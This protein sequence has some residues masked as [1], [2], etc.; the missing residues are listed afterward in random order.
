METNKDAPLGQS[1]L[2]SGLHEGPAGH[3]LPRA[4]PDRVQAVLRNRE[5]PFAI[6]LETIAVELIAIDLQ[7]HRTL[8]HEV[9][10]LEAGTPGRLRVN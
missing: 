5:I 10:A 4:W 9:D 8:D 7:R 2:H 1:C 3:D 6:L